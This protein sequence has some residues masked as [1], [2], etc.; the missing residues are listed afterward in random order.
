M[1]A[2]IQTVLCLFPIL[3]LARPGG[4]SHHCKLHRPSYSGSVVA[5]QETEVAIGNA[6]S[7][8]IATGTANTSSVSV[9]AR[10]A[11]MPLLLTAGL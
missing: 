3:A 8:S 6:T 9:I 10:I 4:G 2:I 7:S 1:L 5:A 11:K